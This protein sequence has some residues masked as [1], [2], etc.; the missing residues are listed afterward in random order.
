MQ[1][2]DKNIDELLE[3]LN[4]TL[5]RMRQSGIEEEL[6][7]LVSGFEALAGP[8]TYAAV[9]AYALLQDGADDCSRSTC[10]YIPSAQPASRTPLCA[11]EQTARSK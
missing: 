5:H 7:N 10:L 8:D 9:S 11:S 4:G 6:F 2:A 3:N 1:R